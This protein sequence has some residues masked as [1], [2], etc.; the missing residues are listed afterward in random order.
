MKR[1]NSFEYSVSSTIETE[2]L[3]I[4]EAQTMFHEKN[5]WASEQIN[6]I[7]QKKRLLKNDSEIKIDFL[8]NVVTF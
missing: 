4:T 5:F 6:F 2:I 8:Q 3:N 7:F 1:T